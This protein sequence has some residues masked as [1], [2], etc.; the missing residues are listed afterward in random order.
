MGVLALDCILVEIKTWGTLKLVPHLIPASLHNDDGAGGRGK[1]SLLPKM[2]LWVQGNATDLEG[3]CC[4]VGSMPT[5]G[6]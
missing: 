5:G 2:S 3:M 6:T 1:P 4:L